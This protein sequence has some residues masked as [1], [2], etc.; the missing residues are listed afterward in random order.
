MITTTV[1][2]FAKSITFV[3]RMYVQKST[4]KIRIKTDERLE[5]ATHR[6]LVLA[7]LLF[8]FLSYPSTDLQL[9]NTNQIKLINKIKVIFIV[10]RKEI[11]HIMDVFHSLLMSTCTKIRFNKGKFNC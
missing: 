1:L 9:S 5:L 3:P 2:K 7:I 10:F 4:R 6:L 8:Y 11:R